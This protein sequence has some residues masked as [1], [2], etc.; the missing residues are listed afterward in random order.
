MSLVPPASGYSIEEWLAEVAFLEVA[1][2]PD[3]NRLAFIARRDDPARDV[4]EHAIWWIDLAAPGAPKPVRLAVEP[5]AL[6]ELRWSSDGKLLSFLSTPEAPQLSVLDPLEGR[7]RR[8][9]DPARFESGILSHDWLPDGS[10]VV[11]SAVTP[12]TGT[13]LQAGR[14]RRRIYGDVRRLPELP[15]PGTTLY[16]LAR[17]DFATGTA[18]PLASAEPNPGSIHLSPDGGRI[19]F[20]AGSP[21]G[22]VREWEVSVLPLGPEAVAPVR[23]RNWVYEERVLWAGR[24]LLIT[25][26][27]EERDGRFTTTEGRLYR[28]EPGGGIARVA[29]DLEGSVLEAVP[30]AGGSILAT[31]LVSTRTRIYRIEP[32]SGRVQT[33]ADHRGM[34]ELLTASRDG[35]RIAFVRYDRRF[36]EIWLADGPDGMAAARALTSFNA[37]LDRHPAPEVETISWKNREGDTIE[38]VLLWPPGRKGEKGLPLVVHLH[39]GPFGVARV[40]TVSVGGSFASYP[41][42]LASRGFLVLSPNFRGG[43]G[44]GDAFGQALEGHRCSRPSADVIA[45]VEHLLALGWADRERVGVTGYS[46]GGGLTNCL[47]GRSGLFR[48]AVSGAGRWNDVSMVAGSPRGAFWAEGFYRSRPPWEDPARYQDESPS[49]RAGQVKTPTL[50]TFGEFDGPEQAEEMYRTLAWRGVPVELLIYPGEG[51]IFRKPS[52]KRTRLFTEISWLERHLLGRS[53]LN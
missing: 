26:S 10:G 52:H 35:R 28:V 23:T 42:L 22:P 36:P 2:S 19:A 47:I 43:A 17:A 31:A 49:S 25:G 44:R 33:L 37:A 27:G 48:A 53:P 39:G 3:G 1:L 24:D 14:E 20:G 9:T 12:P 50:I 51:H 5:A 15:D 7:P 4:E 13:E 6:R 11:L 16:R 18:V 34:T 8:V 30:L 45:G 41:G 29:P 40:E 46:G 32:A 38:G 21:Y